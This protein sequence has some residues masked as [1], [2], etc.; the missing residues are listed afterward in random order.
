MVSRYFNT[1]N[2]YR[3]SFIFRAFVPKVFSEF[4]NGHFKNV[5]NRKPKKSFGKNL[6]KTG[7]EHNALVSVFSGKML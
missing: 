7:S 3:W 1:A 4:E 6:Q 5:Q 2:N